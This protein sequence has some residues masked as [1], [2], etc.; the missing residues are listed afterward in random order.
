MMRQFAN[1]IFRTNPSYELVLIDRLAQE[2]RDLID[3][4]ED[5]DDLYGVLRPCRGSPLK[6]RSASR[7]TAL[8]LLTLRDPGPIPAYLKKDLGADYRSVVARLVLDEILE[9]EKAGSFV[10][11]TAAR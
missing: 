1:T 7:A 4:G 11:G 3:T 5:L 8:L 9:V 10:S 6:V 2:D